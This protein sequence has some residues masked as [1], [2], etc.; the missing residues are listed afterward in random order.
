MKTTFKKSFL[1]IALFTAFAMIIASCSKSK[2][3]A[4]NSTPEPTPTPSTTTVYYQVGN[5]YGDHTGNA[6]FHFNISYTEADGSTVTIEDATL[7]WNKS[8]TVEAPFEAKIEGNIYYNE[9][10]MPNEGV[11]CFCRTFD[12]SNTINP[13][14]SW[15]HQDLTKDKYIQLFAAHPERLHFEKTYKVE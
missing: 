14:P 15:Y 4:A 3:S 11:F 6:C 8:I 1:F 13:Y 5:T 10:D 12:V 9:D 2:D 7:P